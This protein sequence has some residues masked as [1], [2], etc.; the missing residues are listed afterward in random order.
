MSPAE[1]ILIVLK[2]IKM[3]KVILIL[4]IFVP[5]ESFSQDTASKKEN[6]I[7]FKASSGWRMDGRQLS[8]KDFKNEIYKVPAAIPLYRKGTTNRTIAFTCMIPVV[9]FGFLGRRVTDVTSP[10]FGKNN[11]GYVIASIISSGMAIYFMTTS[12][13]QLKKAVRI[14]NENQA[15][16]Y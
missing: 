13:K 2:F 1:T 9:T 4:L 6:Q 12:K 3:R 11:I 5:F 8:S 16:I 7:Y 10:R 15:L 14:H